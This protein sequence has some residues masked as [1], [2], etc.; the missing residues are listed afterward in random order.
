MHGSAGRSQWPINSNSMLR[1]C[2]Y[3]CSSRPVQPCSWNPLGQSQR[4]IAVSPRK[5]KER[6]PVAEVAS[7]RTCD[8]PLLIRRSQY[9]VW[10]LYSSTLFVAWYN[11][12][13]QNHHVHHH[14]HQH[15]GTSSMP[16][17]VEP[18][19][20]RKPACSGATVCMSIWRCLALLS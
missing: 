2:H 1:V 7:A 3:M 10:R 19:T 13:P 17:G 11:Q 18:S 16:V 20:D 15:A 12:G 8:A 6:I 4:L 5:R 14:D 9:L